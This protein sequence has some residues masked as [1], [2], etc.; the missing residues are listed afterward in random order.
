VS[1]L[2]LHLSVIGLDIDAAGQ[3]AHQTKDIEML[4]PFVSTAEIAANLF[5]EIQKYAAIGKQYHHIQ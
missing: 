4:P 1:S 5:T 3:S 2:E